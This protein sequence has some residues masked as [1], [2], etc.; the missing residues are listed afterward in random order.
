MAT[1]LYDPISVR[2]LALITKKGAPIVFLSDAW[3]GGPISADTTGYA[4]EIPGDPDT[5]FALGLVASNPATVLVAASDLGVTPQPGTAFTWASKRYVVKTA[6]P[7]APDGVPI[8][9]TLIAVGGA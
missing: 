9:W 1:S 3:N 4:V 2:T 5:Y 6:T 8:L 7:V